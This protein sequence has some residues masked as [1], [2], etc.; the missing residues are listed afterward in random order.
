MA[1]R[2]DS[3]Y[4]VRLKLRREETNIS[5]FAVSRYL[6]KSPQYVRELEAGNID[7]ISKKTSNCL[8]A[9]FNPDLPEILRK[10]MELPAKEFSEIKTLI[11]DIHTV[12]HGPPPPKKDD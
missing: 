6:G 3:E 10:F 4:G 9:I 8:D 7:V 11:D 5:L 1:I 12:K 2:V